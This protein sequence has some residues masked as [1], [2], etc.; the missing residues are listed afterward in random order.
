MAALSLA[1]ALVLGA[2]LAA[3]LAVGVLVG[4]GSKGADD[5]FLGS[6]A[7]PWWAVLLSIVATETS[8]VTF[9]SIP[10][11][12]YVGGGNLTFLQLAL[13]YIV[14][15]V[16]VVLILLPQYFRGRILTA[17]EV[18]GQRF[19]PRIKKL[20]S[21]LFMATRT[22][23]DGLRLYLTALVL[24]KV[25]D[26][27][28]STSVLVM[29][30]VTVV[31]TSLGGMKAVVWTDCLQFFVYIGGALLAAWVLIDRIPGG[32]EECIV[33]G[34]E[35]GKFLWFDPAL[36]FDRPFTFWAGIVGGAFLTLGTHG[37]DQMMVQRYLSARGV[38]PAGWALSISGIVV[39]LQFL[40]FLLIGVG[41]FVFYRRFPPDVA[42]TKSDEVFIQFMV[43]H[44]RR[45]PGVLGIVLGALLAAAMST[46]S[47]SLN[48]SACALAGDFLQPWFSRR[49]GFSRS[50]WWTKGLVV[51]F[52]VLQVIVALSGPLWTDA[53][54]NRVLSIAGLT[55]G[56]TLGVFLL[57]NFVRRADEATAIIAFLAGLCIVLCVA[58]MTKIAWS[59]YAPI[60]S[61]STL[62]VGAVI[63]GSR[64][65]AVSQARELTR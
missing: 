51:L 3:T 29:G 23:A 53:V 15:R 54:V 33:R 48:S 61:L 50:L 63:A 19:G 28:I 62:F 37:V 43:D 58:L 21:L 11:I 24:S 31:Y 44:L 35:H 30:V 59:W 57:G 1:D 42:F 12:A 47:S 13:G 40:L 32:L 18:L 7:V 55:T 10:G 46:L 65:L 27:E 45:P 25:A 17:Y 14:G 16:L 49:A 39:F 41:L 8:T 38:R 56:I 52:G 9:L 26:L 36:V 60:G 20:A 6:R 64:S 34:R 22:L 2:Y 5:Y 4:R